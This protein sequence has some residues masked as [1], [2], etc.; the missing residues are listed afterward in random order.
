MEPEIPIQNP[1]DTLDPRVSTRIVASCFSLAAFALALLSGMLSGNP[2]HSVIG[3]ALFWLA[4]CYLLGIVIARIANIAVS[5]RLAEYRVERP[6]P[7]DADLVAE[8]PSTTDDKT[9]STEAEDT[10]EGLE[11]STGAPA[12][13]AQAA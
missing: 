7:T 4:A 3:N 1:E 12:Q 9:A 10:P 5:E 11:V 13:P 2:A 6:I 8:A